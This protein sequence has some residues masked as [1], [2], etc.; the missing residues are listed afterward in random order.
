M[1]NEQKQTRKRAMYILSLDNSRL[2]WIGSISVLIFVF[3]FLL[4]YWIGDDKVGKNETKTYLSKVETSN[5]SLNQLKVAMN[6]FNAKRKQNGTTATDPDSEFNAKSK[7][8]S[9]A[10]YTIIGKQVATQKKDEYALLKT[11]K[12]PNTTQLVA[13]TPTSQ[14]IVIQKTVVIPNRKVTPVKRTTIRKATTKRMTT[15]RSSIYSTRGHYAI[16]VA[17]V[18]GMKSA[19]S[20]KSRLQKRN[21]KTRIRTASVNG[22]KYYRVKVGNFQNYRS[23]KIILAKLRNSNDGKNSFIVKN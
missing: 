19:G 20:L 15:K 6:K 2:F 14:K 13:V 23:A 4:G 1:Y 5:N 10:V 3:L 18:Q 8:G 9:D 21:Y 16:Q 12:K 17:S 22:K 11:D 7:N